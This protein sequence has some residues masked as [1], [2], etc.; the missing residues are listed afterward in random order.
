M[1]VAPAGDRVHDASDDT[2]REQGEGYEI[3]MFHDPLL[4]AAG[5]AVWY[6]CDQDRDFL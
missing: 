3:E 5:M 1:S 4:S 2:G 6:G